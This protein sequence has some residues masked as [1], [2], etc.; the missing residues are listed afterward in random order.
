MKIIMKNILYKISLLC[1][2]FL[3]F[4]SCD[5]DTEFT[6]DN[7]LQNEKF[8][9]FAL[10]NPLSV[11]E[12]ST[13]VNTADGSGTNVNKQVKVTVLR[14]G[15]SFDNDLTVS[16]TTSATYASTTDFQNEGDD[17]AGTVVLS[18]EGDV[19]IPAGS[20]SGAFT[21]SA[22]DN[23]LSDGDKEITFTIA[24]VSDPSYSIGFP[25]AADTD[26]QMVTIEDDDCPIDIANVWSGIWVV[27]KAP[28]TPGSFNEDF[29]IGIAVGRAV[30][31]TLDESN[32]AGTAAFLNAVDD[33]DL[34]SLFAAGTSVPLQFNTCPGTVLIG[35]DRYNL[36]FTQSGTTAQI[37]RSDE[38]DVFGNGSFAEDGSSF[39]LTVTY[40]NTANANFDEWDIFFVRP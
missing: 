35:P 6:T 8:V 14:T 37:V 25:G 40:S 23:V 4:V 27:D 21:F 36:T 19:V 1:L 13:R 5:E 18:F 28:F 20:T 15:A 2:S 38:P 17:A 34:T 16:I 39:K 22:L 11:A 7:G 29:S 3:V 24:S 30:E 32:P 26:K 31:L 10:D 12:A 33:P 9:Y